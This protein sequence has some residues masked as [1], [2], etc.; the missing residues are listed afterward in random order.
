[1][2]LLTTGITLSLWESVKKE[3]DLTIK[4]IIN[5][6]LK[7]DSVTVVLVDAETSTRCWVNY[8]MQK[9]NEHGN[10]MISIYI[11]NIDSINGYADFPVGNPANKFYVPLNAQNVYFS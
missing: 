2:T 6:C 10:V 9:S 5:Q 8:E 7:N 11:H 1:M 3:G 4:R